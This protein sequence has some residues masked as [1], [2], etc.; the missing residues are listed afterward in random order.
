MPRAVFDGWA[1]ASAAGSDGSRDPPNQSTKRERVPEA[2]MDRRPMCAQKKT[3]I[4]RN[5]DGRI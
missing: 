3:D 1:L 5:A 2:V 4:H